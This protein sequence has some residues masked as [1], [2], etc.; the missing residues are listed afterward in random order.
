MVDSVVQIE[1]GSG[2]FS[3]PDLVTDPD[4]LQQDV[5]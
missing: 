1:F 5:S 4:N 3:L 2:S